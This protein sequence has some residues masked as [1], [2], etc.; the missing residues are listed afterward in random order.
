VLLT[1]R[2]FCSLQ[3]ERS[4][5]KRSPSIAAL[6]CSRIAKQIGQTMNDE[7]I[8]VRVTGSTLQEALAPGSS[9]KARSAALTPRFTSGGRLRI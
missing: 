7:K 4:V 8:K 9:L 3:N 5:V 2:L 1:E 6:I